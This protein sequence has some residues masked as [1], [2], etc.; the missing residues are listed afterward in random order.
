[1]ASRSWGKE[2]CDIA[3]QLVIQIQQFYLIIISIIPKPLAKGR[4]KA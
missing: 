2:F 3:V 1:M 4:T